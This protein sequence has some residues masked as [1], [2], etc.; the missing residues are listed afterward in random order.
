MRFASGEFLIPVL[1]LVNKP[2][3]FI[4][5]I[6]HSQRKIS[7]RNYFSALREDSYEEFAY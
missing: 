6:L 5:H 4:R 3:C 2:I 1:F 7:T